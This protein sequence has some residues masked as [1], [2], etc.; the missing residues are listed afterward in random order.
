MKWEGGRG[1]EKEKERDELIQY[2]ISGIY[3]TGDKYKVYSNINVI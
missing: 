3:G 1:G 2:Y